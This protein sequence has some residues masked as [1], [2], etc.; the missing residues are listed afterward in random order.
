MQHSTVQ[1]LVA[2]SGTRAVA[3]PA[4]AV[5]TSARLV[6]LLSFVSGA[7]AL[8]YEI[9]WAK[10]LALTFGSTTLSAAAVIA[11]FMGGMGIGAWLYPWI[12][13]RTHRPLLVY[14][15][16][17]LGIATST[18]LLTTTFYALP[19]LFA[20]ASDAIGSGSSLVALRFVV[21]F[22]LLLVPAMLMGATFPALC[23]VLIRT[24]QSVDHHLGMIY[25]VNTIGA[26]AGV[27]LAG[28][29]LI[30]RI[31]LKASVGVANAL[32]LAVAISALLLLRTSLGSAGKRET[33]SSETAIPT[34]LPRWI[35]GTVLLGSGFA[36]L[37]YEIVW[38]RASRY[39]FGNS[40]YA[41]TTVLFVF[42]A[43]LGVGSMLLRRTTRR[44]SAERDLMLCQCAIAV[45]SVV[46]MGV[47]MLVLRSESMREHVSIFSQTVKGRPWWW[48]L[49]L[50]AGVATAVM[51]PAALF[52]GL[53]FP[54]ASRL[55][56]G[57]VRKLGERVGG[58]YLLANLGSILG[59]VLGAVL[60]LPVFG[61]LGG[62]KVLALTSVSMAAL[63]AWT[64]RQQMQRVRLPLAA[65]MGIVIVAVIVYPHSLRL[66][67]DL[68]SHEADYAI[69]YVEEGDLATVQVLTS[70]DRPDK[71]AMAIDGYPIG[72]SAA[73]VGDTVH[74]K[75]LLLAHLPMVLDTRIRH[76][77]NVGLGSASTLHALASYPQ[78][79][80][81]DCVEINEAVV[82]ASRFFE[83]ASV[84]EDPRTR[85]TID[86]AVHYLLRSRQSY[87]LIV[88]DGKQQ[89]SFSGNAVLLCREFYR[90]SLSR[91][92]GH[93][94]FVQWIPTAILSSD[95]Q[96][97]LRTA[98][99]VFPHV[100]VFYFAPG[101]PTASGS[102]IMVGSR[103]P[104]SGRPRM[105]EERYRASRA[106]TDLTGYIIDHPEALLAHWIGSKAEFQQVLGEGPLNTWDHLLLEYSAYKGTMKEWYLARFDNLRVLLEAANLAGASAANSVD[107]HGSPF[108]SSTRLIHH[109]FLESFR[110]KLDNAR[111]LAE[112]ATT[113]NP[114]DRDAR[115]VA[116]YFQQLEAAVQKR[117][118]IP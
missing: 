90:Y 30:E 108:W 100:N 80:T 16:L 75:Q 99:D 79:E 84:L 28:L 77:L 22:L 11:G 15:A 85:I 12:G 8:I 73:F 93:G 117:S 51:F 78:L 68:A 112:R 97:H 45:L 66:D 107:L 40:T 6:Y 92:S 35:T 81:L 4:P 118:P 7:T 114:D 53:S 87:D 46:A 58:A 52:M 34:Q 86:D 26:A 88:S 44:A 60:L 17:E 102:A 96:I 56:L 91:M 3:K 43:G 109:A 41:L 9:T 29:M 38:F 36:T 13:R 62:T 82:R 111:L 64:M 101:F 27:L 76:T 98:C 63:I 103:E 61:T 20:A 1:T 39:L 5:R 54:L 116:G 49:T 69:D 74:R 18:A 2:T 47:L 65:A 94:L 24:R 57:D 50:Q 115:A 72:L 106:G 95:F 70:K 59:S 31:G 48:R 33:K 42:L 37:G 25:G 23:A 32:N 83:E 89:I 104:L 71:K 113:T 110:G 67:G 19:A 14:G 105:T 21:I 10:M 55:F